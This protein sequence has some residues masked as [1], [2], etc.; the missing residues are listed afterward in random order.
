MKTWLFVGKAGLRALSR[1]RRGV[2]L[3]KRL[4]PWHLLSAA[5]FD[6]AADR[7]LTA[8]RSIE[9]KGYFVLGYAD[10]DMVIH[11]QVAG[12]AEGPEPPP[13][14]PAGAEA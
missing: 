5:S 8:L 10:P 3:P 1:N 14:P 4:G 6:E 2:R 12:T 11:R 13:P 9:A 7:N